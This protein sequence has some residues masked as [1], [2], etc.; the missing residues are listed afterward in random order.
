MDIK[1]G[2]ILTLENGDRVKVSLEVLPKPITKLISGK[3]YKLK[4]SGSF[5]HLIDTR[6]VCLRDNIEK[7]IFTFLAEILVG[8][9]SRNI[10]YVES[11]TAYGMWSADN[12]DYVVEE[13]E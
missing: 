3:R 9:G 7:Y 13:I 10:F 1:D 5:C 11:E 8:A 2:D 6:G 12:I 4:C